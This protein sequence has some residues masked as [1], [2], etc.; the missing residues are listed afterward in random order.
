MVED[1]IIAATRHPV[2]RSTEVATQLYNLPLQGLL[3]FSQVFALLF[4]PFIFS[5]KISS[6]INSRTFG[7]ANFKVTTKMRR[8]RIMSRTPSE[9][10]PRPSA[11][12]EKQAVNY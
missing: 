4:L 7:I 1:W 2:N 8:D 12:L 11:F 6:G 3:F 9:V 10:S 5:A